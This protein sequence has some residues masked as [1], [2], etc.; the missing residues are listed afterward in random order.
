VDLQDE[1]FDVAE[2]DE[3]AAPLG[4]QAGVDAAVRVVTVHYV[5]VAVHVAVL[6]FPLPPRS[7]K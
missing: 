1:W 5:A 2:V 4:I 7:L 6:H 3:C